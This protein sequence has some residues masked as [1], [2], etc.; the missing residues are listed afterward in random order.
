MDASVG[1]QSVSGWYSHWYRAGG[2]GSR[3]RLSVSQLVRGEAVETE[4][5]VRLLTE[6]LNGAWGRFFAVTPSLL[7]TRLQSGHLF[8][9]V[10]DQ[11]SPQ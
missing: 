11:P 8:V 3:G 4:D 1:V 2:S 9:V 10:R 7:R 5:E 6:I